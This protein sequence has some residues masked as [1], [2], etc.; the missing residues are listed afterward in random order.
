MNQN[1]LLAVFM[2]VNVVVVLHP[3]LGM[4]IVILVLV[5][6]VLNVVL[7]CVGAACVGGGVRLS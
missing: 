5:V 2:V 1:K 3:I 7:Y 4:C 6:V